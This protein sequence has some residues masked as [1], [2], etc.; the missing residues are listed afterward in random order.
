M[1]SGFGCLVAISLTLVGLSRGD[2]LA[3]YSGALEPPLRI[4]EKRSVM[5]L[6]AKQLPTPQQPILLAQQM[7]APPEKP[8]TEKPP[9]EPPRL[10][11]P[12]EKP[13]PDNDD[14]KD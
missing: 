9:P 2:A 3:R 7:E 11:A 5:L 8:P 1:K 10:D 12:P 4:L 14:K 13:P 6:F